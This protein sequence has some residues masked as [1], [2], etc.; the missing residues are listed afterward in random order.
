MADDSGLPRYQFQ[1]L[2]HD[3]WDTFGC[4]MRELLLRLALWKFL[5]KTGQWPQKAEMD[6]YSACEDGCEKSQAEIA[7]RVTAEVVRASSKDYSWIEGMDD[8]T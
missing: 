1:K 8:P 2:A 5:W 6:E 4:P 7:L 3:N